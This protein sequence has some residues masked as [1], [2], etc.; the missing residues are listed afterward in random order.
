MKAAVAEVRPDAMIERC[1]M[2]VFHETS[3]H[4]KKK[5]QQRPRQH[6]LRQ[7]IG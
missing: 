4:D 3:Q 2:T 1:H 5:R 7:K 6:I